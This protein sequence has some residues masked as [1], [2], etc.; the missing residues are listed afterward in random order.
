MEKFGVA[1]KLINLTKLTV[2][3]PKYRVKIYMSEAF[4]VVKVV[5]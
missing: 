3:G 4:E 2:R 1:K 5:T